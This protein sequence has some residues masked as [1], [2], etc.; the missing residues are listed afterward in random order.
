MKQKLFFVSG[1]I[2]GPVSGSSHHYV[3]LS[4]KEGL[5][6]N[7]VQIINETIQNKKWENFSPAT[8]LSQVHQG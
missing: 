2:P 4:F 7:F 3:K 1:R 6:N 5:D 8:P